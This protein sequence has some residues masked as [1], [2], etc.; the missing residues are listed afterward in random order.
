MTN[1]QV[2]ADIAANLPDNTSGLITPA[3]L[4]TEMCNMVDYSDTA[5]AAITL[6]GLGGVPTTRTVNGHALSSDVTV[7]ASDIGLG[8]VT[9]AAQVLRTEMGAANGV[10]TLESGGK[11]PL[12]QI[13]DALIGQVK[14]QGSWNASTNTPTLA[15][16][17]ASTTK[18]YYYVTSTAGT[19]FGISFE[20]GDW[21]ISD[22]SMWQKVDNTD[23]VVSVAG[24]IG[25]V[26]LTTA[27][28]ADFSNAVLAASPVTSVAGR[29]GVITLT[30]GDVGLGSVENTAL[31]TWAGSANLATVGTIAS[32]TWNGTAIADSYI[33]SAAAWNA[34]VSFPGFGTTA[35]TAAEGNDVRLSD[36]RTPLAHNQ[37]WSTIT[38]TPTTLSGY[39]ITDAQGLDSDLTALAGLSSNGLIARTAD[40]AAATRTITGTTNQ[41]IVSNGDGVA[42][43]PTLSLPQSIATTSNVQFGNL[44]LGSSESSPATY[45]GQLKAY[46]ADNT[47]LESVGGIELPVTTNGYGVKIQA[48]SAD[49]AALAIA[50]RNGAATWTERMRISADGKVGIGTTAPAVTLDVKVSPNWHFGAFEFGAASIGAFSDGFSGWQPLSINPGGEVWFLGGNVGIGTSSPGSLLHLSAENP[51]LSLVPYTGGFGRTSSID[52]FGTFGYASNDDTRAR[53]LAQIKVGSENWGAWESAYMAFV[54]ITPDDGSPAELVHINTYNGAVGIGTSSP[55]ARLD[56]GAS[57]GVVQYIYNDD[58]AN[59]GLGI[60]LSGG[61]C[62]LSLFAGADGDDAGRISFGRRRV[63]T[64]TYTER[65]VVDATGNIGIGTSSPAAQLHLRS[66]SDNIAEAIRLDNPTDESDNGSKI[67]WRNADVSKDAAFFAARRIGS[68]NGMALTFGTAEDWSTAAA[69]EKMRIAGNGNVGINN[70]NPQRKL[71]VVGDDSGNGIRVTGTTGTIG[72]FTAEGTSVN[73]QADSADATCVLVDASANDSGFVELNGGSSGYVQLG[74][75]GTA[76]MQVFASGSVKLNSYGAGTLQTDSSGNVT[77]SSDARLKNVTGDFSRGLADV[78][79]LTPRTYHWNE[80]SGMNTEDENVGFIAQEVQDAIP[81]AVGTMKTTDYEEDDAATGKKVRKSKREAAEYLTLSD[82]PLIAALVNAVKELKAEND[83]LRARV[84]ALENG[85]AAK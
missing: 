30:A 23:A 63:D 4:R 44:Q 61:S 64:G 2:K 79:K 59:A 76:R 18:G 56:L 8:N 74:T 85:K 35:G 40:G 67:V 41:V 28:L 9:N 39:G 33:S 70:T 5:A 54:G 3:K 25:A 37:A 43:N 31:S 73:I 19:Q 27:D 80:K 65:M 84:S 55:A 6:A 45:G 83:T 1:A 7:T 15:D 47:S 22:G 20:V 72:A 53:R 75:G 58:S 46:S 62:E 36:A 38:S 48:L 17:P 26:T 24:R 51:T 14:Y 50:N 16:P 68:S 32:G 34:K 11:L 13:P 77:A 66:G 10:A 71:D 69:T 81:E 57:T 12:S 82:R 60:N 21:I 29:T 49:G 52:L 78:L 42:G